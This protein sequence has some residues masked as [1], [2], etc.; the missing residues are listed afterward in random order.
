[1]GLITSKQ[2]VEIIREIAGGKPDRNMLKHWADLGRIDRVAIHARCALYDE[3][4]IREV[5]KTARVHK[6]TLGN[7]AG[8]EVSR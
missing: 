5:A 7:F 3:E 4:Q 2:A 6:P 1:M 8:L